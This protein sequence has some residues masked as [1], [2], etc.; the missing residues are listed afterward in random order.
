MVRFGLDRSSPVAD[1]A[2]PLALADSVVGA[3]R[4]PISGPETVRNAV[5]AAFR[6]FAVVI[7]A[8]FVQRLVCLSLFFTASQ[9]CVS[10]F[11]QRFLLSGQSGVIWATFDIFDAF[12]ESREDHFTRPTTC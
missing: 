8:R 9:A 7:M 2:G 6:R 1:L 11:A 10:R 12:D 3:D 5:R 4:R